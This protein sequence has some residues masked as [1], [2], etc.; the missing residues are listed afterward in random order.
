MANKCG[1]RCEVAYDRSGEGLVIINGFPQHLGLT[2]TPKQLRSLAAT[3]IKL[4]ER[5]E[6]KS[7]GMYQEVMEFAEYWDVADRD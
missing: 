1:I 3:L 5:A 2:M 7:F 6:R 4:A